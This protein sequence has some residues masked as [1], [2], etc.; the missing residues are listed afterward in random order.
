MS[1]ALCYFRRDLRLHDNPALSQ[2]VAAHAAVIPVY[3]H[4]PEEE[5]PWEPGG[6]GRWWLHHSLA[7]LAEGLRQRGSRLIIRRGDSLAVLRELAQATGAAAVYWNRLYEP[8]A[9]ARDKALKAALREDG[10]E[11]ESHNAALLFETVDRLQA[12]RWTFSGFH[13]FL[14]SLSAPAVPGSAA[15]RADRH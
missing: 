2:A 8:Q 3:I 4:A 5:A 11:V 7:A 14:E 10:L 13:P 1:T 15:T 9:I 12:G 6:A